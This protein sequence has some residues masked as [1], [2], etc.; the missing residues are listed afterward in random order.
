MAFVYILQSFRNGKYYIGSTVDLERR[1]KQHNSGWEHTGKSL[2]PF[3]LKFS[4]KF[5]SIDS[6]RKIEQKLKALKR[7][8]YVE[9]I[10]TDGLIKIQGP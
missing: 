5:S 4:Q 3:E 7:R 8:D 6:A 9:K 10:I 2:G 1:L